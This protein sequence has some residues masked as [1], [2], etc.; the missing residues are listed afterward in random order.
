MDHNGE[1]LPVLI[2]QTGPLE[3][4]RWVVKDSLIVGRE[5]DCD[6]VVADRQVSRQHA[7]F[8]I[9]EKIV[10]VEDLKSKNGTHH[11]GQKIK[12]PMRLED[13][14]LVQIALAQQFVYLSSDATLPLDWEETSIMALQAGKLKLDRRAHRVW[15]EEAEI[16]PPLSAAQFKLLDKLYTNDGIVSREDL[17]EVVG[18]QEEALGISNQALDALIRR[19]RDRLADV[20]KSHNYIVTVRGHGLRLDNPAA[21]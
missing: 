13:G 10:F 3:G 11:N 14:D 2:G 4:K 21:N 17:M 7:R 16:V 8:S 18:G 19:L 6:I 5:P 12:E 1:E 9:K 15:I 20:D